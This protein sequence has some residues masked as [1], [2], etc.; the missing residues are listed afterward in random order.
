MSY[1]PYC[2]RVLEMTRK[3]VELKVFVHAPQIATCLIDYFEKLIKFQW[4]NLLTRCYKH[5]FKSRTAKM[6]V[7]MVEIIYV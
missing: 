3:R 4:F 2:G 5:I 6:K 7:L 1:F